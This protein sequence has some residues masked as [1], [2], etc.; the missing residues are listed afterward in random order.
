MNNM[1]FFGEWKD[2]DCAPKD[3]TE[4]LVW[5]PELAPMGPCI[6]WYEY[7]DEE[8]G[9]GSWYMD[10]GRSYV[11]GPLYWMSIPKPPYY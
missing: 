1:K 5:W 3:G 2:M 4:I 7:E 6:A 10:N 11:T 8:M 9:H